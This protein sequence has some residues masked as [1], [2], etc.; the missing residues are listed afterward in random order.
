[1]APPTADGESGS[2]PAAEE[3]RGWIGHQL[4]DVGGTA[5]GRVDGVLVD[6]EGGQAEWLV[7][8]AGRLGHRT[9]VPAR[10]AVGAAGRVWAP[11][12]RDAIRGAPRGD[13]SRGLS[14]ADEER[15]LEHYGVG[16]GAAG[17]AAELAS[18]D[19]GAVTARP[20]G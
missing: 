5:V 20:I 2:R 10:H 11:Y 7:V 4:D 16:A 14:R 6:A 3:A 9:L 15:L 17:R 13:G 1:M 18:R 8:R 12:S 19:P